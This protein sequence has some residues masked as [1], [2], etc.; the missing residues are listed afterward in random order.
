M[1]RGVRLRVATCLST[2]LLA[3][4]AAGAQ[5]FGAAKEKVTLLRKLPALVHLS[6]ETIAV[7]V[8]GHDEHS[9][10]ARDLQAM[11]EAEI[12]KD[13]PHLRVTD[14]A[15]S[16]II[17]C[18]ITD[19]SHPQPTVTSRPSLA[20]GKNAPKTQNYLRVTGSLSVSFQTRSAGGAELSSDNVTA[21]YDREFDSSGNS[22]S[23]G[24]KGTVTSAWKRVTGGADSEDLNPP[25]DAE[26]RALLIN[27]AVEKIAE[28][29]VNTSETVEVYLAKQK[30]ALDEGDKLAAGGLWERALETFESA[31]PDPKPTEDAY[32]LYDTGVAYEALAYKAE[33]PKAAM[34]YLDEAAIDYGKA[35]D[36]RPSEKYFLEPQRRIEDAIAH[37]RQLEEER[38]PAPSVA[39][40]ATAAGGG[41]PSESKSSTAAKALTN[42]QVIAMVKSGMDDDTVVQAVRSAKAV[43]FD[44]TTAGQQ[45]LSGDGVSSTVLAAMKTRAERTHLASTHSA[46][47]HTA[48]PHPVGGSTPPK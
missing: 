45:A 16:A 23:E 15:P 38:H 2:A 3:A 21:K 34:K 14:R 46:S 20:V 39:S 41:T 29:I 18:R 11:L 12:T 24:V 19:F 42:A 1:N 6:G 4:A 5:S 28:H 40:A 36:S 33:D 17:S 48:T 27:R 25:T 37:Y 30:G 8:T 10:L 35:I 13:D 26:L 44:L 31:K 43:S 7:K 32:R 22:I 47:T 9:D